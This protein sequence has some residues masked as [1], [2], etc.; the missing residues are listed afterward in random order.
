MDWT[1][2]RIAE[3]TRLW[4]DGLPRGDQES[5]RPSEAGVPVTL[6]LVGA[7]PLLDRPGS[8]VYTRGQASRI[9]L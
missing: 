3:L 5:T 4:N 9:T 7:I 8:L 6:R 1:P 2:E